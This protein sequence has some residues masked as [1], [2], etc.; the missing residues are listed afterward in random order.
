MA[1]IEKRDDMQT[2]RTM[3]ASDSF[4]AQIFIGEGM[5]MAT[6]SVVAGVAVG[7]TLTLLQQHLGLIRLDAASLAIDAYPVELRWGDVAATAA[8]YMLIATA[9]IRL[10]VRA[11][12]GG[13][14][15]QK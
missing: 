5:L 4:I 9:V 10:T 7:V 1:I 8:A 6:L 12:M 13:K 14:R 3:G 2:L 11:M 15:E